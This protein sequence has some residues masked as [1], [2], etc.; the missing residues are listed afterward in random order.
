MLLSSRFFLLAGLLIAFT[1]PANFVQA[2]TADTSGPQQENIQIGLSTD[3]VS[4]TT[5]F[6]G[7]VL[8]IFGAL[9]NADPLV[10]RQG[11]YDVIV[12]L[13]GPPRPTVVRKKTRILGM[14]INTQSETFINV[15]MSYSLATTRAWQDITYPEN[16]RQM[17]LG[18]G[19]VTIAPQ[20]RDDDPATIQEF[21]L[22]LRD[23]KSVV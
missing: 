18:A 12:V 20:D 21:A 6:S 23:L 4:I 11:R 7:A 15:P 22:A 5:D 2:Q 17:A 16:Y 8:T 19:N 1:L 3:R 9:D 10:S 14:W 13:E